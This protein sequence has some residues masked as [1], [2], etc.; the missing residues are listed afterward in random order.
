MGQ[1]FLNIL[2]TLPSSTSTWRYLSVAPA[3]WWS[4]SRRISPGAVVLPWVRLA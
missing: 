1:M 3:H 4:L 2:A